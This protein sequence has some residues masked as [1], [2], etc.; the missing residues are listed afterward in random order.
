MKAIDYFKKT[1]VFVFVFSLAYRIVLQLFDGL[2]SFSIE[3][4][5]KI[6][7]VST[8]TALILGILN[9]FFKVEF[10]KNRNKKQQ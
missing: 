10:I 1:F 8:L 3:F 7:F 2:E 5:L 4:L 6:L 9:Y